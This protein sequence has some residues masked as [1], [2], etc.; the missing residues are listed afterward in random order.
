MLPAQH[1]HIQCSVEE[2]PQQIS[3]DKVRGQSL[4]TQYDTGHPVPLPPAQDVREVGSV[5]SI[6]ER[7]QQHFLSA[8]SDDQHNRSEHHRPD[9]QATLEPA[10]LS[11]CFFTWHH[12]FHRS[13]QVLDRSPEC[14]RILNPNSLSR[15]INTNSCCTGISETKP[16]TPQIQK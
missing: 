10:P 4:G 3:T 7:L 2:T 13:V 15:A 12:S 9:P 14:S 1:Q 11:W 16:S 8:Q 6:S 5:P